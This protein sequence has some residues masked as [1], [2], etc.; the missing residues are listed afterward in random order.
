MIDP[1]SRLHIVENLECCYT[2]IY[3]YTYIYVYIYIHIHIYTYI[4][5]CVCVCMLKH[6]KSLPIYTYQ[7]YTA[8]FTPWQ[9]FYHLNQCLMRL[10]GSN[11]E[12]VAKGGSR[13]Q[14][15]FPSLF[16]LID[17]PFL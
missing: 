6:D 17:F 9:K 7:I 11:T 10:W 3:T 2:Y 15:Q 13:K 14:Q 1:R 4:C 5:V 16:I 12:E 8:T